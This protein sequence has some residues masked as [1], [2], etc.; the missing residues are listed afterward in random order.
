MSNPPVRRT[1]ADE[2]RFSLADALGHEGDYRDFANRWIQSSATPRAMSYSAIARRAGF[3]A[4]SFPRDV[5]LG[6]KAL[7]PRSLEPFIRGL[8][9]EGDVADAFRLLV[10]RDLRECR[11]PS[12]S[13][14]LIQRQLDKLR[15]RKAFTSNGSSKALELFKSPLTPM[16]FAAL[17]KGALG[18]TLGELSSRTGIDHA[19]LREHLTLLRTHAMVSKKGS[20]FLPTTSHVAL[21]DSGDRAEGFALFYRFAVARC[22]NLA[23]V[24]MASDW[25]LFFASCFSVRRDDMPKLKEELRRVLLSFVDSAENESGDRVALLQV[26][27]V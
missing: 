16:V 15:A 1:T 19:D 23:D 11:K 5:L 27:L 25:R 3:K 4:R 26:G 18:A 7:S 14:V 8:C 6:N 12:Q 9:M 21:V 20:R 13:S 17:G 22:Q 24:D 10:A 2:S